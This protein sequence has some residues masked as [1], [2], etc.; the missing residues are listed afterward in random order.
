MFA[1]S[2]W[3][4]GTRAS[5]NPKQKYAF[6]K[7][8]KPL[9]SENKWARFLND[10]SIQDLSTA[11]G[12]VRA[13]VYSDL[14]EDQ[15]EMLGWLRSHYHDVLLLKEDDPLHVYQNRL[16]L[17]W[18]YGMINLSLE[19]TNGLLSAL[20]RKQRSLNSQLREAKK[21]SRRLESCL[22]KQVQRAEHAEAEVEKQKRLLSKAKAQLRAFRSKHPDFRPPSDVLLVPDDDQDARDIFWQV[23]QDLDLEMQLKHDPSGM[24][25]TFWEEQKKQLRSSKQKSRR[26]NP[27]VV[28][29]IRDGSF[30]FKVIIFIIHFCNVCI[31]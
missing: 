25:T 11:T 29:G 13:G 31:L 23:D 18:S 26:W 16:R 21:K 8:V 7:G 10:W 14:N 6:R 20:R 17:L 12:L 22:V 3:D 15:R 27:Q 1:N 5:K 4:D 30:I 9:V 28:I 2:Y 19:S 24:L